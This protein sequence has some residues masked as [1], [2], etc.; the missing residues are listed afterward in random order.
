MIVEDGSGLC[1][2][3]SYCT[4]EE[5]DSYLEARRAQSWIAALKGK[6]EAALVRASDYLERA[7][8]G[9]W[10]GEKATQNQRLSYPRYGIKGIKENEIPAWLKEATCEGAL[11]ELEV[12][13]IFSWDESEGGRLTR[14]KEGEVEKSYSPGPR[15]VREFSQIYGLI[16]EHIKSP[17]QIGILRA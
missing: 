16:K 12:P 2:A 13:G 1:N 5:A 17:S 9:L 8:R 10:P 4:I 15:S 11:L 7:Y 14:E 6:K 3:E